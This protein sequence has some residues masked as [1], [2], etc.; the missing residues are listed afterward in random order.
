MGKEEVDKEVLER[1][2]LT[3]IVTMLEGGK[4]PFFFLC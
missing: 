2:I 3:E 1:T 4:T